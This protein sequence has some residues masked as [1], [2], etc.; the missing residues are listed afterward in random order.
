MTNLDY[1]APYVLFSALLLAW[2]WAW[3]RQPDALAAAVVVAITTVLFYRTAYPQYQMVP[4]VLGSAWAVRHWDSIAGRT[5][6][7]LAI[8]CY[9]R[10]AR[11]LRFVLRI[12]RRR[13]GVPF[14]GPPSSTWSGCR[15]FSSVARSWPALFVRRT[16]DDKASIQPP[17]SKPR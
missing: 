17:E 13:T 9:C 4:F 2:R 15:H 16:T 14:T 7:V 5:W 10:L 1:L 11:R 8:A 6:R 12:R 3:V